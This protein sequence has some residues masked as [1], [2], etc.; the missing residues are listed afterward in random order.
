MR[1]ARISISLSRTMPILADGEIVLAKSNLRG[2]GFGIA[3]GIGGTI[4]MDVVMVLTFLIA[5]QP[6]DMFFSMVGEKLGDG[7][8]VGILVHNLVGLT[9]GIVFSLLVLNIKALRIDSKRKG[10]V[11][12]IAA[13]A[14]TIP[15]GCI[16]LAIWLNQAI[17][18]VIAFSLLPHLVWGTFL[19][20]TVGYGLRSYGRCSG[21]MTRL[22][23]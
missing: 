18:D 1:I 14:L 3:G 17:L 4:L 9:G 5:G 15:L 2:I 6:A 23:W 12:G 22:E 7:A 11:L 20:C 10:L 16:P 21:T 13:G 19:G 8:L